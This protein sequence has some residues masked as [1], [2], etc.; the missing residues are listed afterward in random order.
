MQKS[1]NNL[2]VGMLNYSEMVWIYA[3][4]LTAMAGEIDAFVEEVS[5]PK[6]V[7]MA[8]RHQLPPS[9]NWCD[10]CPRYLVR[11]VRKRFG[12]F[13]HTCLV[14]IGRAINNY[15]ETEG[16][17]RYDFKDNTHF[18]ISSRIVALR[19]CIESG[20]AISHSDIKYSVDKLVYALSADCEK[21]ETWQGYDDETLEKINKHLIDHLDPFSYDLI[22]FRYGLKDGKFVTRKETALR[23]GWTS[24]ANARRYEMKALAMLQEDFEVFLALTE[25]A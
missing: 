22:C 15:L 7:T 3:E 13:G 10:R 23:Y 5:I 17:I 21:Y 24:D 1:A 25:I 9:H 6:L 8:R 2:T 14:A 19:K 20:K 4:E 11:A 12:D 16:L 18:V